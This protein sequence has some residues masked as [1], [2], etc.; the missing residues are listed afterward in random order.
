MPST[1]PPARSF[2]DNRDSVAGHF[3]SLSVLNTISLVLS[4]IVYFN[5][6]R[7][8]ADD[9]AQCI[10]GSM[11][12]AAFLGCSILI[13]SK[14]PNVYSRKRV[15]I[16]L[17]SDTTFTLAN[18]V[19]GILS[20]VQRIQGTGRETS[21]AMLA[22]NALLSSFN[23][24]YGI[25]LGRALH[26]FQ[27]SL[28]QLHPSST[29]DEVQAAEQGQRTG[30]GGSSQADEPI[31]QESNEQPTAFVENSRVG[32]EDKTTPIVVTEDLNTLPQT[33][34]QSQAA[35]EHSG[36]EFKRGDGTVDATISSETDFSPRNGRSA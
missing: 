36:E 25:Y 9:L 5:H 15:T 17:L 6:N 19:F 4:F 22:A 3:L 13:R 11:A 30:Q 20:G 33:S 21:S 12:S 29:A 8:E 1:P 14:K 10:V 7:E 27:Q 16:A 34:H 35:R 18:G 32:A 23:C 31:T 2:A 28:E 24:I 26:R